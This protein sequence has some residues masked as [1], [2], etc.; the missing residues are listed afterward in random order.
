MRR[1]LLLVTSFQVDEHGGG[2]LEV[3]LPPVAEPGHGG[4]VDDPVVGGPRDVHYV[5]ANHVAFVVEAR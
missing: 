1:T 4:A 5:G 2:V 3:A